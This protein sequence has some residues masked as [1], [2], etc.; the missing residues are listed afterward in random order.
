[1]TFSLGFGNNAEI[2]EMPTDEQIKG[3]LVGILND[4]FNRSMNSLRQAKV[5]DT[6]ELD[7]EYTGVGSGYYDL[8]T[9]QIERT[10]ALAVPAVRDLFS[11]QHK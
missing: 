1:V 4:G 10:A 8:V 9:E 3:C 2:T 11:E 5:I 7:R 6:S